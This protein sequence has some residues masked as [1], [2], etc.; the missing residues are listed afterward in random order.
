MSK[1][2]DWPPLVVL[3]RKFLLGVEGIDLDERGRLVWRANASRYRPRQPRTADGIAAPLPGREALRHAWPDD[4]HCAAYALYD[5]DALVEPQRRINKGGLPCVVD[6]GYQ[7]L[8]RYVF[9]D[10]DRAPGVAADRRGELAW[11]RERAADVGLPCPSAYSTRGGARAVWPVVTPVAITPDS[12]Q[13]VEVALGLVRDQMSR[14]GAPWTKHDGPDPQCRDWTRLFRMPRVRR[15]GNRQSFPINLAGACL[16]L[17]PF[18]LTAHRLLAAERATHPSR[19]RSQTRL[20]SEP[21]QAA[22][23]SAGSVRDDLDRL[24]RFRGMCE[25]RRHGALVDLAVSLF[26]RGAPA[27]DVAATIHHACGLT[28]G[29]SKTERE[30]AGI[31]TWAA[32]CLGP[33]PEHD[34]GPLPAALHSAP[35]PLAGNALREATRHAVQRALREAASA[36][37]TRRSDFHQPA[38]VWLIAAALGSSKTRAMVDVVP[39]I[40]RAQPVIVAAPSNAL[41]D[42]IEA[43]I[44]AAVAAFGDAVNVTRLAGQQQ[45]CDPDVVERIKSHLHLGRAT[46]CRSCPLRTDCAGAKGVTEVIDGLALPGNIIVMT[47]ALLAVLPREAELRLASAGA[48]VAVDEKPSFL[49]YQTASAAIEIERLLALPARLDRRSS[50]QRRIV[51]MLGDAAQD[52]RSA[53]TAAGRVQAAAEGRREAEVTLARARGKSPYLGPTRYGLDDGDVRTT[54]AAAHGMKN[55]REVARRLAELAA[56]VAELPLPRPILVGSAPSSVWPDAQ[57]LGVVS[58]FSAA[59]AGDAGTPGEWALA[60][61]GDA[62]GQLVRCTR[63]RAIPSA[64]P[65]I[66]LDGTAMEEVG[67]YRAVLGDRLKDI[68]SIPGLDAAN[69]LRLHIPG[70]TFAKSAVVW[71]DGSLKADTLDRAARL[72]DHIAPRI[73]THARAELEQGRNGVLVI[74]HKVVAEAIAGDGRVAAALAAHGLELRGPLHHGM[75]RGTNQFEDCIAVVVLGDYRPNLAA[76]TQGAAVLG[77]PPAE[78]LEEA[79]RIEVTQGLARLRAVHRHGENLVYVVAGDVVP[80]G[81]AWEVVPLSPGRPRAPASVAAESL[82][83]RVYDVTGALSPA[84]VLVVAEILDRGGTANFPELL[85]DTAGNEPFRSVRES[86]AGGMARAIQRVMDD[87]G[88]PWERRTAQLPRRRAAATIQCRP[89]TDASRLDELL[90]RLGAQADANGIVGRG[91]REGDCHRTQKDRHACRTGR[92]NSVVRLPVAR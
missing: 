67:T 58:G 30:L 82:A 21:A 91:R 50:R 63:T 36:A 25:G 55:P 79:S 78:Y 15:E 38:P 27:D 24:A 12:E 49:T 62:N 90:A 53:T 73:R 69:V 89:R 66:I 71:R 2:A 88:G 65:T 1:A 74:S 16:D 7:V 86:S 13:A 57:A 28:D 29:P 80:R 85:L 84:L 14:G 54:F 81:P 56:E 3:R 6:L 19:P 64:L 72:V 17:S 10:F 70:N 47:H 5:G 68:V 76:A 75:S 35:S 26:R 59:L 31:V 45:L 18:L 46:T 77:R 44:R 51:Q 43:N 60:I 42:E 8:L 92:L 40:A 39:T 33:D 37:L 48:I 20:G 32:R 34:R 4:A 41:A 83:R 61:G 23:R 9:L 87:V 11:I 22:T 52:L